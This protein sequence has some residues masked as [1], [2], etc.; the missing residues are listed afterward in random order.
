MV[1]DQCF[2]L[3]KHNSYPLFMLTGLLGLKTPGSILCKIGVFSLYIQN[4]AV[5]LFINLLTSQTTIFSGIL[6]PL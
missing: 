2:I 6:I 3:I 5:T 4:I 1:K